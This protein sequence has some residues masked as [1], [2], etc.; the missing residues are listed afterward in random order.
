M[1]VEAAAIVHWLR[2]SV[3]AAAAEQ[4]PDGFAQVTQVPAQVVEQ[5]VLCWQIPEL[6]SLP[7]AQVAPSGLLPQT[8]P[9][10]VLGEAQSVATVQVVLQTLFVVSQAYGSQIELVTVLHEPAPSQV[11]GG[12]SVE[13]VQVPGTQMAPF[14]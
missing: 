10:Q 4:L 2:G 7:E 13:P 6:H 11:R 9:M 3:P 14:G 1:Q 8:L 5:Q 12:V